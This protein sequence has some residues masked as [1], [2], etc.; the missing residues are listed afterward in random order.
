MGFSVPPG[1]H[2]AREAD[3]F[4]EV[5]SCGPLLVLWAKGNPLAFSSQP[6]WYTQAS[7]HRYSIRVLERV[8]KGEVVRFASIGRSRAISNSLERNRL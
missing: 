5:D 4:N 8:E 1:K 3:W 6:D 2:D 7:V